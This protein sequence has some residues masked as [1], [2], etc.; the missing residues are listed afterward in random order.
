MKPFDA[1]PAD[2]SRLLTELGYQIFEVGSQQLRE[3]NEIS[4]ET[5][6]TNFVF[7]HESRPRH[8]SILRGF[9]EFK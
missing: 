3:L 6:A 9:S 1:S 5:L 4:E 2:V 8:L 7:V